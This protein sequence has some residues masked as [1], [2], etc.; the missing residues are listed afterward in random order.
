[1]LCYLKFCAFLFAAL[2]MV[3]IAGFALFTRAI[4]AQDL[5][6]DDYK[7]DAVVVLTGG[8]ERIN[9]GIN[10]LDAHAAHHLFIS[11]V[12]SRVTTKQLVAM[13]KP[14]QP[15]VA[16]PC[17][18]TLGYQAHNTVQNA[19]ETKDWT[20]QEN[21]KSLRLVTA[22]YHMP[23]ALLEFQAAMP[24]AAILPHPIQTQAPALNESAY[25]QLLLSEYNKTILT[26][27]R[28]RGARQ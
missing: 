6:G 22:A 15:V 28:T 3:W 7:T 18:I 26:W 13:W 20:S 2:A 8:P 5:P 10:L 4:H 24:E 17:C 25:R 14:E 19:Q 9:T 12:D 1:M 21:V 23:R 27:L 16:I 11:G